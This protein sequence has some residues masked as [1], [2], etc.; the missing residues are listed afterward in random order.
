LDDLQR[1]AT[2]PEGEA[3]RGGMV[4]RADLASLIADPGRVK[5][6]FSGFSPSPSPRKG[7]VGPEVALSPE[8]MQTMS[9]IESTQNPALHDKGSQYKGLFQLNDPEFTKYGG[10]GSIY[11]YE[12]NYQ[13][14]GQKMLAEG[15]RAQD[16]LGRELTPVEQYMVHQQGLAGTLA[17]IANPDQPAWKSFQ[18]ASQW[19]DARAK[20]AIWGNLSNA[21]KAQFGNDVNN[22]TSRD[23][24]NLWNQQY[25][26]KAVASGLPRPG[27][28][29]YFSASP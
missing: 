3:G 14:A 11:D 23:F 18:S 22:V 29:G 9:E 16:I 4:G 5:M 10:T 27:Q 15:Q 13:A 24:I 21:M 19:S 2:A 12:Q 25:A 6:D 1:S 7:G 8:H 20:E 17:H 26:D 28:G